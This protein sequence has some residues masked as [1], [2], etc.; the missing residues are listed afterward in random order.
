MERMTAQTRLERLHAPLTYLLRHY[1][2][3]VAVTILAAACLVFALLLRL[4]AAASGPGAATFS[5]ALFTAVS[6]LSV[7][8]MT[9]VDPSHWSFFGQVVILLGMKIGGL[10]I[11]ML[12]AILSLAVSRRIGLTQRMLLVSD[13][14]TERLGE[15]GSLVKVV[16]VT[17]TALELSVAILLFPRFLQLYNRPLEAAWHAL[18]YGVSAFNNAGM[19]PTDVGLYPYLNDW[20]ICL[21]LMLGV[22]VGA[23]GFPVI[24]NIINTRKKYHHAHKH[25]SLHTKLTIYTSAILVLVGFTGFYV[26]EL[27]NPLTLGELNF[28]N[29]VLTALFHAVMPRSAGFNTLSIDNWHRSTWTLTDALMFIGG[30][31]VSTA[32]GIKV[33]T[34]AVIILAIRAEARGDRDIEAFGRRIPASVVRVAVAVVCVGA[35]VVFLAVIILQEITGSGLDVVLFEALSA[36]ATVGLS[37]GLVRTMPAAGRW[38]IIALMFIGR[39]GTMTFAAALAMRDRK[40]VIRYPE[41]RPIIG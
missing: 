23:L 19:V 11:M 33:T 35:A 41:E 31:S 9:V 26:L 14:K 12:A 7:T 13:T 34:L 40:R 38:V 5:D 22:F 25:W 20:F 39:T 29:R 15:V 37:N 32:S 1:P 30:G 18:F 16:I 8:G 17:T 21:P 10:G 3:R 4:P 2:T 36:Y 27:N 28:S 6:A 24:L